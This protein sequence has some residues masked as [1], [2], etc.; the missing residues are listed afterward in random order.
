MHAFF[1]LSVV[2]HTGSTGGVVYSS[3]EKHRASQTDKANHLLPTT[4]ETNEEELTALSRPPGSEEGLDE[5]P[6]LTTQSSGT[7]VHTS[8]SPGE[9]GL[10]EGPQLT[11]QTRPSQPTVAPPTTSGI[12]SNEHTQPCPLLTCNH[13]TASVH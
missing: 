11:T 4:T 10:S 3:N 1:L 12:G 9:K 13:T 6:Q 2:V 5:H 8:E 7:P